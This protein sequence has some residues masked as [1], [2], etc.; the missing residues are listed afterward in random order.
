MKLKSSMP[1]MT[2]NQKRQARNPTHK[3][4]HFGDLQRVPLWV[5]FKWVLINISL[6]KESPQKINDNIAQHSQKVS[7]SNACAQESEYTLHDSKAFAEVH[8]ESCLTIKANEPR[9]SIILFE[10]NKSL[11]HNE[12]CIYLLWTKIIW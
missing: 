9:C 4:K 12:N 3:R 7:N 5:F 6:W 2:G 11:L 10:Y 8:R 1:T